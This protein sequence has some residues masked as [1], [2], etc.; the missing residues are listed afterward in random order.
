LDGIATKKPQTECPMTKTTDDQNEAPRV[1]FDYPLE[2]RVMTIDGTWCG[3]SFLIDISDTEAQIAVTGHAA[4]L[5]EF[6]LLL[7]SFGNPVFRRC[8]RE[9]VDGARVGVRFNKTNIGIKSFDEVR[10]GEELVP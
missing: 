2:V 3:D 4:E 6:F 5:S 9:W 10:R 7:T 8:K 1:T